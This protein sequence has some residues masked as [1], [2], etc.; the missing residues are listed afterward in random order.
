MRLALA[1]GLACLFSGL[2]SAQESRATIIG[3]IADATSAVV[4]GAKVEVVNIATNASVSSAT[5]QN[6]NYEVP[7]LLPGLYRVTVEMPGFKR[8]VRDAIELRV[9]DRLTLDFTLQLGE[10]ADS[11]VVTGETPLLDTA[12]A[13]IGM[14]MDERRVRELPVVGGNPFYL[15]RLTA[16]V[17]SSAGRSAGNPMDRGA[18]TGIIVNGTRSNSSEVTLDGAPNM[19]ERSGAFSPPQDLVQEFKI[20]T[21]TFDASL[22]HAAGAVT[23]VSMK[24]GTNTLHGTAYFF[25]SRIR[26]VPWFTNRFIYD[27]RT[28]PVTDEKRERALEGWRHR[29]W[30]ATSS[31]PVVLPRI[32]NGRNRTF[33]TFGYEG[34]YILRNLGFTGTVPTLSQRRGDFS[35]LL[36]LG[37]RYQIYDPMTITPAPAGRFRRQPLAG[38]IIPSNRLDQTALNFLKFWPEPNQPGTEDFRQN[39]FRTRDIERRNRNLVS[40]VDHSFTQNNRFFVRWSNDRYDNRAQTLPTLAAGDITTQT[41]YG[42]VVDDV[43]VFNPQLLLNVRYG[44]TYENPVNSRFSQGFD[45]RSLGLPKTLVDEIKAKN[46]PRGI[47]FPQVVVDSSAYTN[48]GATGGDKRAIYYQTLA[49]TLTKITGNQSLRFGAEYRLMRENGID[50][51]NIAPRFDFTPAWTRGPLDNSPVAPIGQ[52]LAA[53]L[54]GFPSGGTINVNSSRSEQSAFTAFYA[55]DDWR[56]TRRLTLNIGLRYEYESPTTE[57]FNRTIRD[58][59]FTTASPIEAQAKV[60]YARAPI[61]EVPVSNFR[62]LGGLRFAGTSAQPRGLWSSDKNNFAPR[63]GVAYQLTPRTVIRSGYGIFYDVLGIDRTDVNQGGFNQPT[64]IIPSL[65]NGLTFR[66]TLT[67]PF[68]SGIDVPLG[69]AGG[70]NTFLGRNVIFFNSKALNPYMQ[71]WSFSVQRELPGKIVVDVAYVGNRGTKLAARREMNPT[72]PQYLST[73]PIRD[74][75]VIDYLSEQVTNP[76]FGIPEFAGTSLGNQRVSRSQL[77]RPYPHFMEVRADLPIGYSYFHSLQ[78]GTEKRLSK[79]LTFLASWTWS[80]FVEAASFLNDTDPVPEKVMSNQDFPQRVVISGIFELPLGKGKKL[81]GNARGV[82][83]G[84]LGGWQLQ[85]W[86]EGQSG[87]A[88]GFGNAIFYGNL[89]D[90]PLPVSQRRAERWF[91]TEAGFER[92]SQ[93]QLASNIRALSSRFN[94]VRADGINNFDLSLFKNFRLNERFRLQFRF[95]SYN[96]L[97]HVQFDNPNTTPSNTAFGTITAENGHG[98]RQITTALKLI[99]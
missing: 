78:V 44:L 33:W 17:L 46:D 43:H 28:G 18:A 41:G 68:P 56:V 89:H 59:D 94:G 37:S 45:L 22:G 67:N 80:K 27:P 20:H 1:S 93:K 82:L 86:F 16:G 8:S 15:S 7:Y 98:Q 48:L 50:Y 84:F 58:F 66:A 23:N 69:A 49:G 74:Q 83:E 52:G 12:T 6:G 32:Y 29:R 70:L 55:Q 31:G 57:R 3:R 4:V 40:R 24:S 51:G 73:S 64:N 92:D 13:S 35:D 54:L 25:D 72:P 65:D 87:G 19:F 81:L 53:M 34:L 9:N 88:L 97:N 21:A 14:I 77:L 5:N 42:L 90:I 47:A 85:G 60:N 96:A 99:F 38:N 76:F 26:A 71:R 2:C 39:Y 10:V 63:L 36:Q 91:N 30:G 62:A 61:T 11:I 75:P 95:E 79:G